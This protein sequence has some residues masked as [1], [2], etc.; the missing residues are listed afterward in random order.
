GCNRVK[1]LRLRQ[2]GDVHLRHARA[3]SKDSTF[4][5]AKRF[6]GAIDTPDSR[7]GVG[8]IA[9]VE[10]R[11]TFSLADFC[12]DFPRPLCVR[13]IGKKDRKA[14]LCEAPAYCL[15]DAAAAANDE[16]SAFGHAI[17][18]LKASVAV[19]RGL[20]ARIGDQRVAEINIQLL[21]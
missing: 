1:Q 8:Q 2:L 9:G 17:P 5:A 16:H 13:A 10:F 20:S 14:V 19:S 4:N 11:F 18:S 7:G 21:V 12:S 15:S 3:G 6:V